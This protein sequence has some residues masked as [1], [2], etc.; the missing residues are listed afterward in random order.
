VNNAKRKD[1]HKVTFDVYTPPM[2]DGSLLF[3]APEHLHAIHLE[4]CA[5]CPDCMACICA[6]ETVVDEC[7][8]SCPRS[9][10]W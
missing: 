8:G 2:L 10:G 5:H 7:W 6:D 9:E 3:A 4:G 1:P